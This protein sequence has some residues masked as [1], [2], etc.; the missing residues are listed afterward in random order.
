MPPITNCTCNP[1]QTGYAGSN[2]NLGQFVLLLLG[3]LDQPSVESL[4]IPFVLFGCDGTATVP[5]P[6]PPECEGLGTLNGPR[7]DA[8][9]PPM[10]LNFDFADI[11]TEQATDLTEFMDRAYPIIE[12]FYAPPA[13]ANTV[14]ITP[15]NIGTYESELYEA[16]C[17]VIN[18]PYWDSPVM[19][20]GFSKLIFGTALAFRDEL[21]TSNQM[22]NLGSAYA[23]TVNTCT[24]LYERYPE[25]QYQLS[26][27]DCY[28]DFLRSLPLYDF[29][30]QAPSNSRLMGIYPPNQGENFYL[31]C[32][33][34]ENEFAYAAVSKI[35]VEHPSFLR[36]LN[37]YVNTQL[38]PPSIGEVPLP[39]IVEAFA[40]GL[41]VEDQ[42]FSEW[43]DN[44]YAF[45][46]FS[47]SEEE[48]LAAIF[49]YCLTDWMSEINFSSV[50]LW[51]ANGY[52]NR[53]VT[54]DFYG[55]DGELLENFTTPSN[56]GPL[57]FNF[58]GQPRQRIRIDIH[59]GS[60]SQTLYYPLGISSFD[61]G[62]LAGVVVGADRGTM[63]IET[64]TGFSITQAVENGFFGVGDVPQEPAI[65][66]FTFTSEAG[67]T[68]R[69]VRN[70]S[71][72]SYYALLRHEE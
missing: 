58:R 72:H 36:D 25:L 18:F 28:L 69:H 71:W 2:I 26:H 50:I 35:I 56:S 12:E 44:Q 49:D 41:T 9:T 67:G 39:Q 3:I 63:E 30:N 6:L 46:P 37:Q 33:P 59:S 65:V 42:P 7:N 55:Y 31:A 68:S 52:I 48:S 5:S 29:Y 40:P 21:E 43:Y 54:F 1:K 8:I 51:G 53:D 13:Y 32:T 70:M 17:N 57:E 15:T 45:Q 11:S 23:V 34:N 20:D 61:R 64:S 14:Y 4:A 22:W 10:P 38:D 27:Y 66:T 62:V 47:E 16:E 60:A 24:E 19:R